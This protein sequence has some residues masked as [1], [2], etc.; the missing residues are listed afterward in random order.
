MHQYIVQYTQNKTEY[1][2]Y[3]VYWTKSHEIQDLL[4][5]D[6]LYYNIHKKQTSVTY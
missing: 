6:T 1:V 2:Y 3:T 5:T 4:K